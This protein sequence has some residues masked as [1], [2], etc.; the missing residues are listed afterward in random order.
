MCI[1]SHS[2]CEGTGMQSDVGVM[3]PRTIPAGKADPAAVT[4]Q[5][6]APVGSAADKLRLALV[7]LLTSEVAPS[8]AECSEVSRQACWR[9][10]WQ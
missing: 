7:W 9:K 3:P 5:L 6:Q 1:E 2:S 10:R 4:R 8:E